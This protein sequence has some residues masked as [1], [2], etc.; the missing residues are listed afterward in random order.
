MRNLSETPSSALL[1]VQQNGRISPSTESDRRNTRD[2]DPFTGQP[3]EATRSPP[4]FR[5]FLANRRVSAVPKVSRFSW[6]TSQAPNTPREPDRQS[7]GTTRSS[8]PRFRTIE[9]WVGQQTNRVEDQIYGESSQGQ[10]GTSMFPVPDVPKEYQIE[11]AAPAPLRIKRNPSRR[12]PEDNASSVYSSPTV[13]RNTTRSDAPVF[14]A[15][16]G[17]EVVIPRGSLVPSEVLNA[18][19]GPPAL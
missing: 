18:K 14:H 4:T 6:T 8:V 5:Q 2:Y 3:F 1:P 9:S 7:I 10:R 19:V 17:T 16:P 15:H 11:P 13:N 12:E